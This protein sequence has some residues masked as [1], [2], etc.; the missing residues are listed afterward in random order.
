MALLSVFALPKIVEAGLDLCTASGS[1]NGKSSASARS[2]IALDRVKPE[3]LKQSVL[4][5]IAE[6]MG[7]ELSTVRGQPLR[8]SVEL[9]PSADYLNQPEFI[10]AHRR[11]EILVAAVLNAF[12]N[13]WSDRLNRWARSVLVTLIGN[14]WSKKEPRPLITC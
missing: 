12:V 11:G 4:L 6:E 14:E 5:S 1:S 8:R 10:E 13:V 9:E 2:T 3:Q 7:E